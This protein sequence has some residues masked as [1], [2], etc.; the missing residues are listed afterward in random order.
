[1]DRANER[2]EQVNWLR[3]QADIISYYGGHSEEAGT[4]VTY[5]EKNIDELPDWF[6]NHDRRLLIKMVA[7][8]IS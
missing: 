7:E 8:A 3:E 4:Y 2:T 5:W 6:D 1:M